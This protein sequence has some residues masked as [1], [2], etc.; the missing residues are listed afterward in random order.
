[1][2][3]RR[4]ELGLLRA[5]GATQAQILRSVLAE[6]VLMGLIGAVIGFGVGLLL[7]WY[8][9]QVMLLD[10]AGFVFAV[11]VPWLAGIVV[12]ALSVLLATLAGFG[13][14][15]HAMRLRIAEAI[16]YE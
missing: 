7:E 10:E 11:R 8:I 15:L 4:R 1:M 5:V 9:V 13:P 12:V 2:L 3:Q 16:A 6:A 14:A